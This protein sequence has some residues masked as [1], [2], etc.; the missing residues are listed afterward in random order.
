[1][2]RDQAWNQTEHDELADACPEA[3]LS[4][5]LGLGLLRFPHSPPRI[6]SIQVISHQ[7]DQCQVRLTQPIMTECSQYSDFACQRWAGRAWS[8]SNAYTNFSEENDC[9][10][11]LLVIQL[12]DIVQ[13][14]Q[15]A[16][17]V[18]LKPQYYVS[19]KRLKFSHRHST[20]VICIGH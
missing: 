18:E 11:S 7:H 10:G 1:M 5:L 13:E 17:K 2:L 8:Q 6:P 19:H 3:S 12:H 16:I 15:T 20:G 14:K 4:V 9:L